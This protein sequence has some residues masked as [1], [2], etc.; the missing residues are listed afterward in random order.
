MTLSFGQRT[1]GAR[2]PSFWLV[3]F[4]LLV[5]SFSVSAQ[6]TETSIENSRNWK[7]K[8]YSLLPK[9]AKLETAWGQFKSDLQ[10]AQN[11][12]TEL[13]TNIELLQTE[14]TDLQ[15]TLQSLRTQYSASQ[16]ELTMWTQRLASLQT[17]FDS[18]LEQIEEVEKAAK[19]AIRSA[20]IQGAA[21]GAGVIATIWAVIE[22]FRAIF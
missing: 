22:I 16:E 14:L 6:P 18:I 9:L 1:G 8:Y 3:F 19:A 4:L 17:R 12:S 2:R 10:A 20:R 15:S 7:A 13:L 21:I 11:Y 5:L